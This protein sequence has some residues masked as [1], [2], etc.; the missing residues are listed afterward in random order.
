LTV[1]R[2]DVSVP[3]KRLPDWKGRD[4]MVIPFA[5]GEHHNFLAAFNLIAECLATITTAHSTLGQ[6]TEERAGLDPMVQKTF[7]MLVEPLRLATEQVTRIQSTLSRA[8]VVPNTNADELGFTLIPGDL[9]SNAEEK[10]QLAELSMIHAALAFRAIGQMPGNV[11]DG[12]LA[13]VCELA[14]RGM[15]DAV[16]NEG[17]F[18][19]DLAAQLRAPRDGA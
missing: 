1:I 8:A 11:G 2:L 14:G 9:A 4:S 5:P 18:L 7:A 16:A 10:L 6:A 3:A 19:A 12:E 13:A 17:K 15:D